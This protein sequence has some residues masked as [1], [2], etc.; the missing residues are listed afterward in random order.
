MGKSWLSNGIAMLL[1]SLFPYLVVAVFVLLIDRVFIRV[2][3]KMLADQL[4][5]QWE[6]YQKK[7]RRW[8]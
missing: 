6:T 7:T 4:G 1:R 2:E 5:G 8:I 3:E